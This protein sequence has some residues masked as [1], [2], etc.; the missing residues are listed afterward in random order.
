MSDEIFFDTNI[1]LY[2]YSIGNDS[3][4]IAAQNFIS[5]SQGIIS[6]QV[7]Q[8]L[9]NI[10]IEKFKFEEEDILKALKEVNGNF[11]LVINDLKTVQRALKIHFKY[12]YSYYDSLIIGSALQN[13]CSILY[14]EDLHHNQKIEKSLTIINPFL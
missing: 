11:K 5:T 10:L 9:C 1:I 8:E 7:L 12:S 4:K 13:E 2:S 6:T 14:S 3:K